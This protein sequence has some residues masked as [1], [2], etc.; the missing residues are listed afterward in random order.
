ML[1]GSA[2]TSILQLSPH[3]HPFHALIFSSSPGSNFSLLCEHLAPCCPLFPFGMPS[4]SSS[5]PLIPPKFKT[6]IGI[7]FSLALLIN[8]NAEYVAKLLPMTKT[9]PASSIASSAAVLTSDGIDSPNIITAGFR[10]PAFDEG[11]Q[12]PSSSTSI[13]I[14]PPSAN[15]P[16]SLFFLA[17]T[18]QGGYRNVEYGASGISTSPSGFER[19]PRLFRSSRSS[20][21]RAP[22]CMASSRESAHFGLS[23]RKEAWKSL[24][25]VSERQ[26][27]QITL[28]R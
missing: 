23:E 2:S 24:R 7:P 20:V 14:T 15:F 9:R 21:S 4:Y 13:F 3:T 6:P 1:S 27:R 26:V 25:E 17:H 8:L 18:G 5:S 11:N 10:I 16:S 19:K 22:L 12:A 28:R